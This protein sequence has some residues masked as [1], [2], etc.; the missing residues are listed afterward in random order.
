MHELFALDPSLSFYGI[1]GE[2]MITAGLWE[3]ANVREVSVVG[4]WEVARHYGFFRR[5]LREIEK[6][7]IEER[8]DAFIAV[9]YPGFNMRLA[10]KAKKL[11]IPVLYYI[12]PQLWAWGEGRSN[13]LKQSIDLLLTVFPFETEYFSKFSIQAKFSGHPLLDDAN[14]EK[15]DIDIENK[16][17]I[18][19]LPG[20]RIQEV[21]HN[22]PIMLN[23]CSQFAKRHSNFIFSISIAASVSREIY[24]KVIYSTISQ[25]DAAN[26]VYADDS[27]LLMKSARA[28]LIK[29]G[30]S[31][32][33]ACLCRLPFAMMYR[34]SAISFYFGKFVAKTKFLAM[35][36][37]IAKKE[38]VREF[39]Q[40]DATPEKLA[41][42]LERIVFDEKERKQQIIEFASIRNQLGGKGSAR[43]AAQEMLH[44]LQIHSGIKNA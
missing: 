21:L 9:D 31:T 43:R 25:S 4:F 13:K 10:A 40:N 29:A 17:L 44:W 30:T 39:I 35:P 3:W 24:D 2:E 1:G 37:I 14:L 5:L 23:A 41:E 8:P 42:E 27:R 6:S 11:G 28:G 32:L 34:T 12:A 18:A 26:F 33:E 15:T 19:L 38:V 16:R 7:L 20:S 36:N 22:L